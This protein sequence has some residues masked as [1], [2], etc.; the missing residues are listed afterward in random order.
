MKFIFVTRRPSPPL[1]LGG[2]EITETVKQSA[3]EMKELAKRTK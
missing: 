2:A 3:A 1:F